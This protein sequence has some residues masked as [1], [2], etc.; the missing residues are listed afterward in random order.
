MPV[1]AQAT[2]IDCGEIILPVTPPLVF[3]ATSRVSETLICCAV[4]DCSEPNRAFEEVS[5]PV[6]NT[7]S[8]PRNGEKNGNI[9]P[10]PASTSA[11]VVA[12]LNR[13]ERKLGSAA[14]R[15]MFRS[16]TI[17]NGVEFADCAGMETS[18]RRSGTRT[19]VYYCHP[20]SAY[21]RGSN[22]NA[23]RIIRRFLPKGTDFSNLTR[24]KVKEIE[25]WM[26]RYPRETLGWKSANTVFSQCLEDLGI[27]TN[28]AV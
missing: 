12:A 7:P 23:N 4:V 19:H 24:Q 17:D 15:E 21:E 1:A 27:S 20:Y 18:C 9:T 25:Q 14:F 3:A 2:A 16:I 13:M 28:L 6:R 11:S 8:Q 5:E 22:E 26:N 10:V